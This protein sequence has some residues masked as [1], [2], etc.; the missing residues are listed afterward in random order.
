[1]G[2][3]SREIAKLFSVAGGD[4]APGR[5]NLQGALGGGHVAI[6]LPFARAR[7]TNSR[8]GIIGR[9]DRTAALRLWAG[10][11]APLQG[12]TMERDPWAFDLS[13]MLLRLRWRWRRHRGL[14]PFARRARPTW[15][16][17]RPP[18]R[19]SSRSRCSR[20]ISASTKRTAR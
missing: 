7:R 19:A 14:P 10:L 11:S 6:M 17:T 2:V 13:P 4:F 3:G 16:S 5:R 12:P 15:S 8:G 20:T 18:P 9:S 1:P